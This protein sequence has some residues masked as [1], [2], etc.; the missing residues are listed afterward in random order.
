MVV[1]TRFSFRDKLG[2]WVAVCS[3]SHMAKPYAVFL[4]HN[5][6]ME[7]ISKWY[8]YRGNAERKLRSLRGAE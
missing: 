5:G 6:R 4:E 3:S 7:Q 8:L 2:R 1:Y